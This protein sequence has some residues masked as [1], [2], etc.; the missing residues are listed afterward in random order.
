MICF[1][2]FTKAERLS[3]TDI[4]E[5]ATNPCKNGATCI[6]GQNKYTCTCAGGWQGTNCDQGKYIRYLANITLYYI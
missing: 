2:K 6:N 1:N 3:L 4:D 5:C